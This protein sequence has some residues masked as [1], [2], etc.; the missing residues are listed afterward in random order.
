[1]RPFGCHVTILSTI[2]QLGKFDGKADEGFFFGYILNSKAFIVLNNKTRIVEENLQIRFSES[3]PNVVSSG[4]DWLFD[5][6]PLTRTMNYEP[7]DVCTQS[8]GF[9]G[10]KASYNASQARNETESVKY[11]I[12]LPLWT[13][14]LPFSQDLKKKEDN[15]NNTN[16]VNTV[17]STVNVAGTN[18]D[19]ELPFDPNMPALEDVSIFNF[20]SDDEDDVEVADI[21]NL[22]IT[23]QVSPILTT[24]IH[25]DYPFDQVIGDFQSTTQT[26]KMSKNL[27]DMEEVYVCQPPGCEDPY[28]LDRVYKVEKALYGLHKALRAWYETLSTYLLD[29]GFQ[30]GKIN[31]TLIIKRDKGDIFLFQVYVDDI[32]FSSTKKELFNAFE[33]LMHETFQTSSMGEL[34]FF[35]GLQV[36]QK[37]DGIFIS[38]DKYI[39]KILKKFGFIEVKTASTPMETQKPL[40]KDEDDKTVTTSTELDLLFS[41][42]FDELLNGSSKVVSKSSAVSAADALNQRQHHTTP[43]NNHTTPAPTCQVITLKPTVISS[44]NINQA[45]T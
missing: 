32:I 24:R 22:G 29:N 37:K 12:L 4:P 18:E 43:L 21:N 20:S 34:T 10:T 36:K 26:K 17:S 16:N 44:E 5:I 8:N 6:D 15:I 45:E 28:F 39:V 2:D 40:L 11:Y 1:M 42:M 7:I 25:K 38:Q 23:I 9:A 27:K 35:L 41:S 30:R 31:K 19:N 33:R 14:D 3:T 13:A